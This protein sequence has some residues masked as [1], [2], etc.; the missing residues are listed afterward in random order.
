VP[1]AN[2]DGYDWT[3]E[4]KG[5]RLW[6][7]N[8]RDNDGDNQLTGDDGVDPN[9]NWA[10]KWGYDQEGADDI[11]DSDTY[12]GTAAESE[13]E[14]ST[15][16]ALFG[17]LKPKL[18]LDYHSAAA[19][20]LLPAAPSTGR[21]PSRPAA[22]CFQGQRG[23]A[24]ER[25]Q[26]NL[27]FALDLAGSARNPG[28]PSSHLGNAAPNFVP[29]TFKYSYGDPQTVEVTRT[30]TSVR[31]TC[32]GASTAASCTARRPA[33]TRAAS[34]AARPASTATACAPTSP[35]SPPATRCRCGSGLMV[36]RAAA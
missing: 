19:L 12:R 11:F 16:D 29:Y 33:S 36:W 28:R 27:A 23:G 31:S 24:E 26:R 3:F 18:L 34:A 15:L 2:P 5:T 20:I 17:K 30:A 10:E 14:V 13:P 9:R 22:S 6:R 21:T 35:A 8:L 7:K 32:C 1:V 4:R 25:F